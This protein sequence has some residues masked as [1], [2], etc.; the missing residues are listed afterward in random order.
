MH[1]NCPLDIALSESP[2]LVGNYQEQDA[3]YSANRSLGGIAFTRKCFERA[4]DKMP[5]DEA[6]TDANGQR[7]C[8]LRDLTYSIRALVGYSWA[9]PPSGYEIDLNRI[10]SVQD[11]S[12]NGPKPSDRPGTYL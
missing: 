11:P 10:G 8:P 6:A 9:N 4:R 3:H 2:A 12:Q 1:D 5:C 7:V